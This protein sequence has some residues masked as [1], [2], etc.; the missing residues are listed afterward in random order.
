MGTINTAVWLKGI[1]VTLHEREQTGMDDFNRPIYEE[2]AVSVENVLVGQPTEQEI[3]DTLE[4]T[5]RRAVYTLGIPKGDA[6]VW[7]DRKVSFFGQDFRV[8]GAPV[9][10]I[11]AMIPLEWNKKARCERI[12]GI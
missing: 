2:T 7:T 5:G 8:I 3:L 4:L 10:G 12:D 11:E 1:T 9:Q 6:H